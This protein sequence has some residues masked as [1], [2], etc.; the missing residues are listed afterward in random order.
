MST[1]DS[2]SSRTTTTT[3]TSWER[4]RKNGGWLP[5]AAGAAG[6]A[7]LGLVNGLP[8]RDSVEKDLTARSQQAL[9]TLGGSG[10]TVDFTGRDGVIKGTLPDGV[11]K[12]QVL[13]AVADVNGVRVVTFIPSEAANGASS[14]PSPTALPSSESPSAAALALPAVQ[15]VATDGAVVLTGRVPTQAAADALVAAAAAVYGADKVTNQLSVD[16]G[17]SDAGLTGFAAL[18]GA[19]GKDAAATASLA[20]GTLTLS[21]AVASADVQKAVDTAAAAVTGDTAKVVDQLTLAGP[22]PSPSPSPAATSGSAGG[23]AVQA[24]L[25]ALPLVLFP[26]ASNSLT[27]Q[28]QAIIKQAAEILKASPDVKV[29][30]DGHTDDLGSS[31]V[32][33][34]LSAARAM[35]VR[36]Y[37]I[38]LGVSADRLTYGYHGYADPKVANRNDAARAQNRRVTFTVL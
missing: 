34:E 1:T 18:F 15:S 2:S 17:V 12:D 33:N 24:K 23:A 11:S 19:F 7:V 29:R 5:V 4:V 20:D 28:A 30:L 22:A 8:M 10:L 6:L 26:S 14:S 32:N 27:P 21:G 38:Q 25:N 13:Q 35:T 31:R 16:A 36:S 9:A 37:L 3:S